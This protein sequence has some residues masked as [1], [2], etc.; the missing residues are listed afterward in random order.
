MN[1]VS[2]FD[3]NRYRNKVNKLIK[4]E[5][6]KYYH[7]LFAKN[8]NDMKKTWKVINSLMSKNVKQITIKK[9]L[10]NNNEFTS[11]KEIANVFNNYFCS[12]G[13]DLD[14][15]IP[16]TNLD[17]LFYMDFNC[18]DSFG[19]I[20]V[21]S[22]E[23]EA[24]IRCLKNS[25]QNLNS[26]KIQILKESASILSPI[27][28]NIM[29]ACFAAGNF[30]CVLKNA[31]VLPLFKKGDPTSVSNY[32]P[33]SIL[34]WLS[35]L[36]EKCLKSRLLNYICS[37]NIIN[38]VQFGFQPGISTQDAILHIMENIYSNMNSRFATIGI[39]IDFSKC[40]DTINRKILIKK[41]FRY[42]IRGL[43]LQILISYLD[44]RFQSVK[45]GNDLS[46]P[47]IIEIGV[48]QGSVLGPL[49][50]LLYVNEIP[51]IER[52][53]IS[54]LFADDT[55]F[56]LGG[57]EV[58]S[59][60]QLCNFGLVKFSEWCRANRLSVNVLKTNFMLFSNSIYPLLPSIKFDNVNL[61]RSSSVRFLG[62]EIDNKLKF[63]IHINYI[64]G[65]VSKNIGILSKLAYFLPQPILIS[66]Y[67]SLIEPYL[68]YC[69]IIFGGA[70]SSHLEPLRVAQRRSVRIISRVDFRA[71]SSPL[72][73]NLGL[74]KF[75]DIYKFQLGIHM[76]KN[77]DNFDISSSNHDYN[78]RNISY[79]PVF[80]RLTLTQRQSV[81][82]QAPSNWNSIP[83]DIKN[84][85]SL[86][87]FKIN[88]KRYLISLY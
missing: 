2:K 3:N 5:K 10:F 47:K 52:N 1:L 56:L 61:E 15:L 60:F 67:H 73:A 51:N 46:D 86:K 64:S 28:A 76:Y 87:L 65:K 27:I 36:F 23:V 12:V 70:C 59:L 62:V 78:M 19:L 50:F 75:D 74:L 79:I 41:L 25:R 44:N 85:Q 55:T 24:H 45:V 20:P 13:N 16:S 77:L 22:C 40:F 18:T 71:H 34:H 83:L 42:G 63:N 57:S 9:I 4:K 17:P 53:F 32:R 38:P 48:P 21:S 6:S 39:F 81:A 30:P 49:L 11:G 37:K 80:Q 43:P 66:L 54:C 69:P 14:A 35:K 29:N 72:F 8:R 84:S 26:I 68:N 58:N 31:I 88:Y 7:N 33:I 82:F